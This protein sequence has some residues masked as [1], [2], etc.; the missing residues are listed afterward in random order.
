VLYNENENKSLERLRDRIVENATSPELSH[1]PVGASGMIEERPK[2]RPRRVD[3]LFY[4]LNG[5]CSWR[6][7]VGLRAASPRALPGSFASFVER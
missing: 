5:R 2:R 3:D 6:T 4:I 1:S 7:I